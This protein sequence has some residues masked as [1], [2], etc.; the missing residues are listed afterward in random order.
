MNGVPEKK[1]AGDVKAR[2]ANW[3]AEQRISDN[4]SDDDQVAF[5]AWLAESLAHRVAFVRLDAA[6]RRSE[7]LAALRTVSPDME[8]NTPRKPAW[9]K[10][11]GFAG[12]ALVFLALCGAAA[13]YLMRPPERTYS[14]AIG[15]HR[16]IALADGSHVELNT[17]TLLRTAVDTQYRKVWLDRGE[18]FFQIAHDTGH[19]FIVMAGDRSITVLG[20]KFLVRRDSS[21]FEVAV[22]EGRV[23]VDAANGTGAK[24]ALL[25]AGE[26]V[27]A[28]SD[29]AIS[30]QKVAQKLN[31]ELGWRHGVLVFDHTTLADAAAEFNRYNSKKLIVAG[32]VASRL[33]IDGTFP[34]GNA[35]AF[36]DIVQDVFGLRVESRSDETVISR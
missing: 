33:T 29:S 31:D 36:I 15:A 6:W 17:N 35:A 1:Y 26:L 2:A 9:R 3:V 7:R 27:I 8:T 28:R 23:R 12:A 16:T 4:W 19:P 14:T 25:S 10:F 11:S 5:D 13:N 24:S 20:T 21:R 30:R 34:T 22:L 18:V 32:S